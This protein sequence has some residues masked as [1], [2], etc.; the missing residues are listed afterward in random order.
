MALI[1]STAE[2]K[3][4]TSIKEREKESDNLAY[5]YDIPGSRC[6]P[7][8][9]PWPRKYE[10][11]TEAQ[12]DKEL[13]LLAK[14][15]TR[16]F[17]EE[18]G[19]KVD[20]LNFQPCPSYSTQDRYVVQELDICGQK[21]T[22]TGV[23]DGHLGVATVEHTR[24]HLPIIIRDFLRDAAKSKGPSSLTPEA[25]SEILSRSIRSFDDAIAG[26][27]LDLFPGGLES[28]SDIPDAEIRKIINDHYHGAS[29]YN[30][31]RLC[32][33]GTTALVALVDP[34]HEN[35]WVANLG[36]CQAGTWETELLTEVHNGDNEKEVARVRREHP[37]EPEC[38]VDGRVLGAIAPFRCIGDTPFKQ[39][40]EFTR[41]I[42]YNLAPGFHD[43]SPWEEFLVRN[44]TPPYISSEADVVHRKL[45]LG[46]PSRSSRDHVYLVLCSDGLT[47]LCDGHVAEHVA[48]VW[49]REFTSGGPGNDNLALRLLRAA[50]GD[51]D[52][53]KVSKVL[54]LDMDSPWID[55]TSIIVQSL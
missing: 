32:M 34:A 37:G 1:I 54:T 40:P 42:L 26:D 33:Y 36:D 46:S 27:V 30:K 12:I 4:Q 3:L 50:I 18:R 22:L 35:L 38:V 31:A 7:E 44:R 23:F 5:H 2:K 29:N 55:D 43:T 21:W 48:D 52:T 6:G 10:R 15:Q 13:A 25:V 41:R 39:P 20:S 14:P 9:G 51:N 49:R 47:D 45:K 24:H 11:L 28:L 19:W 16:S 17:D 8:D 53:R